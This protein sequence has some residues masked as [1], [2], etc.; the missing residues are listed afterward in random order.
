MKINGKCMPVDLRWLLPLFVRKLIYS[1]LRSVFEL[2]P[3]QLASLILTC[4]PVI[5]LHV[6]AASVGVWEGCCLNR[7]AGPGSRE[8]WPM[9]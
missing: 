3:E 1:V 9:G 7:T 6:R 2:C 5:A 8:H 4:G